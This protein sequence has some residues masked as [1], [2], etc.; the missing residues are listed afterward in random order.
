[1]ND[2]YK[3]LGVSSQA[4]DEE[5]K[6][7]YRKLSM[8]YHPDHHSDSIMEEIANEKMAEINA[9]YD[10]IMNMRRSGN[11]HA[12]SSYIDIRSMIEHGNYTAADNALD[13]NRNDNSAEWNFLKGTVCLSRGWLNDA[14]SYFEKAVRIDPSNREY[15]S[16]F[17]QMQNKRN[18]QMQGNP[19]NTGKNPNTTDTLCSLCQ[20]LICTDC[21]C[22][23]C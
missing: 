6:A 8:Q 13:Q 17:S 3:V 18:G 19:Y 14:Y 20:C 5:I 11:Q 16:A 1:M 2:P 9:A 21:L 12:Q 10:E 15:Q 4:S 7:A 23:C 22:D